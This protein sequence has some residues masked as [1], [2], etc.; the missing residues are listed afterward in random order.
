MIVII[1]AFCSGRI[2][3]LGYCSNV[4]HIGT[5]SDALGIKHG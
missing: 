4:H 5:Y 2:S 1:L 3:Y